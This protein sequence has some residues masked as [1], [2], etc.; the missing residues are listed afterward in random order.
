MIFPKQTSS[1]NE[2]FLFCFV[3]NKTMNIQP[4]EFNSNQYEIEGGNGK[5]NCAYEFNQPTFFI[6]EEDYQEKA[7][8][9]TK[10]LQYIF[11]IL[12]EQPCLRFT[13]HF[14]GTTM[15]S[16]QA[17]SSLIDVD[18]YLRKS[19]LVIESN[20]A[21]S[22]SNRNETQNIPDILNNRLLISDCSNGK[23]FETTKTKRYEFPQYRNPIYPKGKY[24]TNTMEV[25]RDTRLEV[26]DNFVQP[27]NNYTIQV[28]RIQ[29]PLPPSSASISKAED[30]KKVSYYKYK[31][32]C[33]VTY[34]FCKDMS[35]ETH[36]QYFK[37]NKPTFKN[38]F[39]YNH[40]QCNE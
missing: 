14:Q 22:S 25:G 18:D 40:K 2:Y 31:F 5:D 9:S 27:K 34:Q 7:L 26:K 24:Q 32:P 13:Q 29:F 23:P 30:L 38:T 15:G 3:N 16:K 35:C 20:R 39:N 33:K 37:E 10:P 19:S 1:K 4:F 6:T 12:P 17:P 36:H 8:N 28:P 11:D 21:R